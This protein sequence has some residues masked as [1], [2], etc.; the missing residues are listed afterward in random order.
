MRP[1]GADRPGELLGGR[2]GDE[3][4]LRDASVT[5]DPKPVDLGDN[6]MSVNVDSRRK[7]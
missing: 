6:R 7:D 3:R 1:G 2:A 4:V 5:F